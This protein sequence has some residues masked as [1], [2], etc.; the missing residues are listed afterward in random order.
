MIASQVSHVQPPNQPIGVSSRIR[1]SVHWVIRENVNTGHIDGDG[2]IWVVVREFDN[3]VTNFGLTA[4]ASAPAGQ[5]ALPPIYLVIETSQTTMSTGNIGDGTVILA[6]DPTIAGDTQL[7]LSVGLPAQE[8]VTFTSKSGTGPFTFTL[9]GTLGQAHANLDPVVRAPTPA[10]T[11]AS[12][13]VEAQ[14]DATN[15]PNNRVVQAAAFSPGVGQNTMQFFMAGGTATNLL[16]A[17]VGLA[18]QL[19]IPG[20][21]TNLHNYAALGYSHTNTNDLEVDVTYLL[22]T[23]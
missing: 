23:F 2:D 7:V 17:H 8:L 21:G 11:M 19:V 13:L 15:N 10:D 6:A 1:A 5:L 12:V 9:S 20:V 16:F 3:L 4:L 18:D 14:Y 22:Q